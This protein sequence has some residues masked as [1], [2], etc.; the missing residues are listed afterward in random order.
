M[1]W[2][3]LE[4]NNLPTSDA[5]CRILHFWS[6]HNIYRIIYIPLVGNYL[7]YHD[8]IFEFTWIF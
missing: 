8:F 6:F 7:Y 5:E 4:N 3:D 1:F 2:L